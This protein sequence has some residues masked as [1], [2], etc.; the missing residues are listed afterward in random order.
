MGSYTDPNRKH[1]SDPGKVDGNPVFIYHDI[2]NDDKAEV[3]DLKR[4]YREGKVGDVEVKE[5][6]FKAHMRKFAEA[7]R[8]RKELENNIDMAREILEKGAEKARK[9]AEETI[10][11]VYKIVG[12]TNKLNS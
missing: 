2:V 8:K 11:E 3:E 12:I 5:S 7:R 9:V 10:K 1:A 4:R 6:L